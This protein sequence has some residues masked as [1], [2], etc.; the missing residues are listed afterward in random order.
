MP[1]LRTLALIDLLG[2]ENPAIAST[3]RA[4]LL[5][6]GR[7]AEES[8]VI[9]ANVDDPRLRLRAR[10]LLETVRIAAAT[11]DLA[12]LLVGDDPDLETALV[13]LAQTEHPTLRAEDVRAELD[14]LAH[15]VS[16]AERAMNGSEAGV[17]AL[18]HEL[19]SVRGF[20]GRPQ[21]LERVESSLIDE[22]LRTRRG[23]PVSLAALS[24]LVGRRA[25]LTMA[26]IGTPGRFLVQ[27]S[28]STRQ[29]VLDACTGQLLTREACRALLAGFEIEFKDEFLAPVTDKELL[30]RVL[31]N[32]LR[33]HLSRE[34]EVRVQRIRR[35]LAAAD[36]KAP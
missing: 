24:M 12:V 4:E 11:A 31:R 13:L 26:G 20:G 32:L 17:N 28:G 23:L 9:A 18:V 15:S 8:L 14:E 27:I 36:E 6:L 16:V 25:G 30:K 5:R 35:L 10:Q 7:E 29:H 3:A 1:N 19:F 33:L 22:V 34:D 21:D 2:D